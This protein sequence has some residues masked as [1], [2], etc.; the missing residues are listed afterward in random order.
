MKA[1][2]GFAIAI[3]GVA[4]SLDPVEP[5]P[6]P[7][8]DAAVLIEPACQDNSTDVAGLTPQ[9]QVDFSHAFV[10][11]STCGE[12]LLLLSAESS[13]ARFNPDGLELVGLREDVAVG[14][15]FP[16]QVTL[17]AS[18]E[19]IATTGTVVLD[20]YDPESPAA[21]GTLQI[22]TP[23]WSLTGTFDSAV[24]ALADDSCI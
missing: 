18:A 19:E 4:C 9:G 3:V 17:R 1:L 2:Y 16:V 24:C 6:D 5:Q 21:T 22:D 14:Q 13:I 20:A 7:Q 15:A 11:Y 10:T 8:P 23:G 12:L